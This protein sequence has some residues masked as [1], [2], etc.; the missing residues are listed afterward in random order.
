MLGY[1]LDTM[2]FSDSLQGVLGTVATFACGAQLFALFL[3]ERRVKKICLFGNLINQSAFIVMYLFPIFDLSSEG[4]TAILLVVLIVGHIV[5]NAVR[6]SKLAMYMNSVPFDKRGS[7]TAIKEMISLVG[8]I[9]VSLLMGRIAD[10]FRNAD[11]LPTKEYYVICAIALIIMTAIHTVSVASATEEAP[12]VA[13]KASI[14]KVLKRISKNK[15]FIKVV[16]VGLLWNI[17]TALS[18]S[19]YASYLREELTFNFTT[20]AIL[21]TVSSVARILASPLLGKIADK[22]SFA[23]SM[24]I[25]FALAGIGFLAMVFTAPATKWLYA[26]YACLY[27]FAMAGINSG[28]INL[29]YDYVDNKDRGAAMGVKN[30]IGGILAFFTALLSGI[31]VTS[32]QENGGFHIFGTSLYAQQVLAFLSFCSV[33]ILIIYMRCIIAPLKRVEEAY[34]SGEKSNSYTK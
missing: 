5:N 10:V 30:A 15:S 32:I 18:I 25:S 29:V 26:V 27:G 19:F 24:T 2:G 9:T 13:E 11:G 23:T 8:G 21:T 12:S 7:F 33:I 3:S 34:K 20:I 31:I 22:Y 16:V 1:L 6:P 4:R 28:V 14:G 17:A